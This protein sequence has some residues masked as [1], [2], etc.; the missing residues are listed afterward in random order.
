[1][2]ELLEQLK[3]AMN[4]EEARKAITG[5]AM[6]EIKA[7]DVVVLDDIGA[8]LGDFNKRDEKGNMILSRGSNFD[9]D[10]LTRILESRI[11]KP[12]IM[13]SK[14]KSKQI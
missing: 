8:E 10:T 2:R 1:Y 3:F 11:D 6:S 12:T 14:L 9:I 5:V 13:T 4:D 7:A